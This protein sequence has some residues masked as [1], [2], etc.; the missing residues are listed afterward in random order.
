MKIFEALI[1]NCFFFRRQSLVFDF[2]R[3]ADQFLSFRERQLGNFGED[4]C[5]AH[6]NVISFG[7]KF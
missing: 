6:Q 4:F 5:Q 7:R 1:E 2:D 3:T